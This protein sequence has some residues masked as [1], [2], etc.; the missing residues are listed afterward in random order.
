M[1][2]LLNVYRNDFGDC[3]NRGVSSKVSTVCVVNV[4]GPFEPNEEHPAVVLVDDRPVG[5]RPYPKLV[6]LELRDSGKW[7]MFGG[8]YA[9]TS[10]SRFADAVEKLLGS[11]IRLDVLPIH[12]RVEG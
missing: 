1:G 4:E 12:D 11:N 5:N 3:T 2:L 9:G 10:D 8:N 7:T 6:P